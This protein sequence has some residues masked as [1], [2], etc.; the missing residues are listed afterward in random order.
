MCLYGALCCIPFNNNLR[1]EDIC[2][3]KICACMVL[4]VAFP[5][6]TN[7]GVEDICKDKICAYMVLFAVDMQYDYFQK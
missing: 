4:Y 1:V 6:I 7:L 5:L 3:D 2:K